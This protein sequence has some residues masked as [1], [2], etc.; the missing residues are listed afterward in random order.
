VKAKTRHFLYLFALLIVAAGI[1]QYR[2][3][4]RTQYFAAKNVFVS[5]PSGQSLKILSFGFQNLLADAIYIWSIQFY[6]TYNIENRFDYI[7]RVFD[8]I[9]DITPSY[10]DPYI[11]GS[12]IMVYEKRDPAMAIRLLE[13]GSNA[14][15]EEWIFDHDAGYYAFKFLKDYPKAEY[16]YARAAEKP[17]AP[18]FVKRNKAHMV[19]L[20]NNLEMAWQMWMELYRN[21]SEQIERDSAFNH[22]FQIKS[23]VDTALLTQKIKQFR[24]AFGRFPVDLE[25]LVHRRLIRQIPRDFSGRDY[26]YDPN[27]GRLRARQVFRWKKF[28]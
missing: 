6:S 17:N 22:L 20:E 27:S 18:A 5:L 10:R 4:E 14:I 28:S 2:H 8:T 13:K 7:E 15:R 3:D 12:L 19:Y 24:E 16:H 11:I 23:E 21:A 25:E 1:F 26:E 9:T